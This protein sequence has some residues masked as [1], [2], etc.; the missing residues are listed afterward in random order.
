MRTYLLVLES[1]R[2][3]YPHASDELCKHAAMARVSHYLPGP[4]VVRI[5]VERLGP[6]LVGPF[7]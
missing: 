3:I 6:A 5:P 1:L 7:E 4:N 2:H